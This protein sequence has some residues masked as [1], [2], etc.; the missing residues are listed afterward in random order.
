MRRSGEKEREREREGEWGRRD[1]GELTSS[2]WNR[3]TV[4]FS[5]FAS[6]SFYPDHD[7]IYVLG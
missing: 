3:R 6:G 5:G 7:L 1:R 4:N 2:P